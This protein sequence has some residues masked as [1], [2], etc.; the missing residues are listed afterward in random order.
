MPGPFPF[1]T[2]SYTCAVVLALLESCVDEFGASSFI[3]VPVF[4][5][6]AFFQYIFSLFSPNN[7]I[8]DQPVMEL[9]MSV[10]QVIHVSYDK[11]KLATFSSLNGD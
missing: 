6:V 8:P 2:A 5:I 4:H 3:F 10:M 1:L 11:I 7:I 9:I